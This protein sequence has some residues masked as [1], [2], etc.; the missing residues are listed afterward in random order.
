MKQILSVLLVLVLFVSCSK[1]NINGKLKDRRKILETN[2]WS[3]VRMTDNGNY[4]QLP[5]C[6]IDNYYIFNPGGT[7]TWEEGAIN[8]LD[9]TGSGTAPNSTSFIWEMTGDLRYI[10]F[11]EFGGDPQNRREWEILN[12]NYRIL[13]VRESIE[14][15]GVQHR[16]DMKFAVTQK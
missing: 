9:S 1:K 13:D 10:Y 7:G 11:R 12:M 4:A 8:C 14:I 6:Q 3:L 15:N 2:Y 16:I 5:K